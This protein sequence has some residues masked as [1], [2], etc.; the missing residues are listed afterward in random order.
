MLPKPKL[1][2]LAAKRGDTETELTQREVNGLLAAAG[3]PPASRMAEAG[4]AQGT[5]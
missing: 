3:R 5:R 2:H 1:P 4:S